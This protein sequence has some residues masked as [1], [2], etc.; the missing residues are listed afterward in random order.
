MSLAIN[1][2]WNVRLATSLVTCALLLWS[3]NGFAQRGVP[4]R[5]RVQPL[6]PS[7]MGQLVTQGDGRI[8]YL[9]LLR[10]E[11]GWF[12][13]SDLSVDL[14]NGRI[15]LQGRAHDL[16]PG[17]LVLVDEMDSTG[18]RAKVST[19]AATFD[20]L[21]RDA[22]W[23]DVIARSKEAA[24]F[25]RCGESIPP[26]PRNDLPPQGADVAARASTQRLNSYV[27]DDL[28]RMGLAGR[29]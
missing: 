8:R 17:N 9:I 20:G 18:S 13:D 4:P 21:D 5:V 25:L 26:K 10:G 28:I 6:S 14:L 11:P 22:K 24:S 15:T 3:E 1:E 12:A 19:S 27:C 7:V 29:R 2:K 23:L 16:G